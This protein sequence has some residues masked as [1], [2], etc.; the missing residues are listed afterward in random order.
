MLFLLD[1]VFKLLKN[2]KIANQMLEEN[3]PRV[4]VEDNSGETLTATVREKPQNI[5]M[6]LH[7]YSF[8]NNESTRFG[9]SLVFVM[10]MILLQ[11]FTWRF[12]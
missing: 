8:Q 3:S 2:L 1:T 4:V 7:T 10:T 12:R 9:A 6:T 11:I 5:N